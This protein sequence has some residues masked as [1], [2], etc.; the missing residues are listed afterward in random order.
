MDAMTGDPGALLMT[1]VDVPMVAPSTIAAVVAAWQRTGAPIVR[2]AIGDRHGHPVLFDHRLFEELRQAPLDAGAKT[3]VRAY[4]RAIVNVEVD[5]RGCL[6]DVDT[7]E[8]YQA[9]IV[10]E[11]GRV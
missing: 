8:D 10:P 6:V 7:P 2:P 4:T 11:E 1:L 5:D 3:V 9:I